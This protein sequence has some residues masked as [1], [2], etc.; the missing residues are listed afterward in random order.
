M[1]SQTTPTP[2]RAETGG[3]SQAELRAT[4]V[5]D[6]AATYAIATQLGITLTVTIDRGSI[7]WHL[8][9]LDGADATLT[10]VGFASESGSSL[11]KRAHAKSLQV[12]PSSIRALVSYQ[13]GAVYPGVDLRPI[14]ARL[15]AVPAG[16]W[17]RSGS[18][19]WITRDGKADMFRLVEATDADAEFVLH[20]IADVEA[21]VA[22]VRRLRAVTPAA[23]VAD[24]TQ[25]VEDTVD[26]LIRPV[27]SGRYAEGGRNDHFND[28]ARDAKDAIIEALEKRLLPATEVAGA[29]V[30]A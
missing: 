14:E 24:L 8:D 28:G 30:Q 10:P 27:E 11:T 2:S 29:E 23:V 9:S 3:R 15:K 22:E 20:A 25:L 6:L 17:D 7:L 18:M 12:H 19:N 21:L 1:T 5:D 4:L 16:Q 13:V 26:D